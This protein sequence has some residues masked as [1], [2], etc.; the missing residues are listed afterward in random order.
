ME[1][2]FDERIDIRSMHVFQYFIGNLYPRGVVIPGKNIS[3]PFLLPHKQETPSFNVFKGFK[4]NYIF[5]DFATGDKGDC[6][7]LVQ[8]IKG[9]TRKEAKVFIYRNV[10]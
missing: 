3:N 9:Y 5:N 8:R 2:T 6:I 7:T 4:G 1:K 10:L